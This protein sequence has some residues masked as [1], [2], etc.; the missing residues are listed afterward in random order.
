MKVYVILWNDEESSEYDE[1]QAVCATQKRAEEW[2]EANDYDI[3]DT[4]RIEEAE[5][6]D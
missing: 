1:L 6:L 2:C 3:P 4:V 5:V